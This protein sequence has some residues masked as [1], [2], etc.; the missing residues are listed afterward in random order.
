MPDQPS[1]PASDNT[2]S[3]T[4]SGVPVARGDCPDKADVV[5]VGG[6]IIGVSTAYFLSRAGIDVTLCEK[7][8]IAGEQSSRNWGW[9]RQQGRA[10]EEL[11]MMIRSLEIWRTLAGEIGEDVGFRQGGCLYLARDDK[12]LAHFADW[13]THAKTHGLDTRIVN[14]GELNSIVKCQPAD[15]R[16]GLWTTSDGRAEP[17]LAAPAIARAAERNGANILTACAVRGI[18]TAAGNIAEVVT[19]R[20]V[21]RTGTVVCAGGA[22]SALLC[23]SLGI[24]LPQLVVRNTVARTAP[25]AAITDGAVWSSRIAI[26]RRQDE[27]YTIAHGSA[28]EHFLSGASFRN[29]GKFLPAMWRDVGAIRVRP[30]N[31]VL[32][33]LNHAPRWPL[34]AESPFERTRVLNPPPGAGI[35]REMRRHL[36]RDFPT[37]AT[38]PFVETWA[39]MIDV[40]PDVK[41]VVSTAD[42]LPGLYIATG[43]SGH[44]FG[45]GPGAGEAMA[46][47]ITGENVGIDLGPFRLSR[48]FDGSKR[49]L[50]PTI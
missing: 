43:F 4:W 34:D 49:V 46:R 18:E 20:G 47:L 41:P 9:V 25:A 38:A 2:V 40:T 37:L 29:F 1:Q 30:G 3:A 26:R 15:W 24:A 16:G 50:G 31:A 44:G 39:G 11:P 6:G 12:E 19:E 13:L 17:H 35:L 32:R 28:S 8:H 36:D 42:E 21:I 48:F 23:R 27:G 22:W 33:D 10:A 7:G 45:I 5:I 14:P